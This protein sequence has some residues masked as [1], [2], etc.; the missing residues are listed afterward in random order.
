MSIVLTNLLQVFGTLNTVAAGFAWLLPETS[1]L[2]LEEMD[3]LF[4]VV[5]QNTRQQ[6][7]EKNLQAVKVDN[8]CSTVIGT[9]I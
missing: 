7:I 8:T 1:T 4:G 2:S 5:D 9:K 6:D 3:I